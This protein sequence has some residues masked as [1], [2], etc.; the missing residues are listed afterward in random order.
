M[1]SAGSEDGA[2]E[3]VGHGGEEVRRCASLR[4]HGPWEN[5]DGEGELGRA[6]GD[7]GDRGDVRYIRKRRSRAQNGDSLQGGAQVFQG[8]LGPTYVYLSYLGFN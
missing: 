2:T 5:H 6:G 4:P 7:G 1:R 3:K 8:R